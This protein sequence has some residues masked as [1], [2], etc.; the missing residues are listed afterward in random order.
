VESFKDKSEIEDA[1]DAILMSNRLGCVIGGGT[2]RRYSYIDLALIDLKQGID[3]IRRVLVEGKIPKRSWI[4][5]FD[6]TLAQEWVGIYDD[7]PP[8]PMEST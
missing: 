7:S 5:F 6:S 2:G 3:A 1:L 4:Q 8:P